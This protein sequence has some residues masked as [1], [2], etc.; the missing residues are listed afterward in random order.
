MNKVSEVAGAV[1][2]EVRDRT[3]SVKHRILEIARAS[4]DKSEKGKRKLTAAYGKLLNVTSRVV[5]QAKKISAELAKKRRTVL[6][7]A[8]QR[9]DEMIPR[10]Q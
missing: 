9:L 4:R 3:R 10:V 1:V 6:R 7:R 5:S 2:T 8:K